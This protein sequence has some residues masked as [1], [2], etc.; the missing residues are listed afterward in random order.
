MTKDGPDKTV[1]QTAG[2]VAMMRALEQHARQ[3]LFA[4]PLSARM[5]AGWPAVVVAHGPLRAIFLWIMERIGPGFYGAVICRTRVIDDEC[6]AALA[7]GIE[8]VVIV[9]AGMDTRPYRMPEMAAARVWEFDLPDVQAAK[10]ALLPSDR[11]GVAYTPLDLQSPD[12]GEV[13]ARTTAGSGPVLLLCEAVTMYLPDDAI[14]RVLGYAAG[15]PPGSRLIL[16]YLPRDVADDIKNSYWSRRLGW[17]GAFR[18][19]ELAARLTEHGLT[20]LSDVGAEEHRSRLLAPRGRR[21]NVFPGE[22]VV[23]AER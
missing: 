6:R 22:R 2:G 3:P 8:R 11:A 1:E 23:V 19:E 18:P 4:D 15:L 5:L 20:P 12:A 7:G 21:V 17:R 9:G 16:T 10:R 13:L 14:E